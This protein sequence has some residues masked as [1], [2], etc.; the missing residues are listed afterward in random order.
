MKKK[1]LARLARIAACANATQMTGRIELRFTG[2]TV[3]A[4]DEALLSIDEYPRHRHV[5]TVAPSLDVYLLL[6]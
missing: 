5:V 4:W 2:C 6:D 1:I 3:Y